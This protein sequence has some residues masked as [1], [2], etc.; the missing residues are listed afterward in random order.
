MLKSQRVFDLH[1][2]IAQLEER[3][4]TKQKVTGSNPVG[5]NFFFMKKA[6]TEARRAARGGDV[7]VGCVVAAGGRVIAAAGNRIKRDRDPTAHAEILALRKAAL[8]LK[9]ERLG[10]TILYVT[11]E[12]CAM[13]AGAIVLARV[14]R[15]V[16]GVKDPKTG[17]CGSVFRI[18]PNR[19]L[20]HR[21]LIT[22]GVLQRECGKLLKD[23]FKQRR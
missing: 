23:F 3:L 17:A 4:P 9:N 7:P 8:K 11:V 10:G 13:C 5:R 18:L 14:P 20:N 15:V 1:A 16:Y 22:G 2:P 19:K 12:P 21:P 6:L